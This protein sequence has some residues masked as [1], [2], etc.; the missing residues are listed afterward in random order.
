VPVRQGA[1]YIVFVAALP[2]DWREAIVR[3]DA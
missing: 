3:G 1:P 2:A